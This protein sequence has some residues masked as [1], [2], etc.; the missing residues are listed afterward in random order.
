MED[1]KADINKFDQQ[2]EMLQQVGQQL[3][4]KRL[5]E[6]QTQTIAK[7][8]NSL[9]DIVYAANGIGPVTYGIQLLAKDAMMSIKQA[10]RD[11]LKK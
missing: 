11:A 6:Q 1:N 2:E 4:A 9:R 10:F 3:Q 8:F 5:T 7:C